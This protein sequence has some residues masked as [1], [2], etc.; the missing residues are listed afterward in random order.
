M[1]VGNPSTAPSPPAREP[2]DLSALDRLL[3]RIKAAYKPEQ[4]W[5][6]G[7]RARRTAHADSDWDLLVVVPDETDE[8]ALDPVYAWRLQKG[9]GVYADV[10]P[11][12]AR[13]FHE[14]RDVVNNLCYVAT[15]EGFRLDGR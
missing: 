1:P 9:S 10:I 11:C 13:D 12:L 6:F 2:L 4:I 15:H 5:L 7:S 3:T 8:E 14:S